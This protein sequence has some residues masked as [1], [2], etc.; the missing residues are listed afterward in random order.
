MTLR[1]IVIDTAHTPARRDS[2]RGFVARVLDLKNKV[3]GDRSRN[4]RDTTPVTG[5]I[6]LKSASR[7][8]K[9]GGERGGIDKVDLVM[10]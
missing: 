8:L 1:P 5:R 4:V 10:I 3:E 2:Q 9:F 6:S 7:V